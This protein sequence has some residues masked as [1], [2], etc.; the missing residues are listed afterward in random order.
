M[1]P[2]RVCQRAARRAVRH[3][4]QSRKYSIV[5]DIPR[6]TGSIPHAAPPAP[7]STSVFQ[8]AVNAARPR[9]DWTK[10]D[11]SQIYKTPIFELA[12]A[13]VRDIQ[14]D[15][16]DHADKITEHSPQTLSQTRCCPTMYTH[17]H[18]DWR[19]HRRLL[20]LRPILEI[21]DKSDSH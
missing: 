17:E 16:E 18:Q 3:I 15:K 14:S 21:Q 8:N 4:P 19:M 7:F 5:H 10:E 2:S 13:A 12:Y 11:I 20:L 1:E 9:H 6:T